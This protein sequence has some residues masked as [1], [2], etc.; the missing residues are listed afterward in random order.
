MQETK[1]RSGKSELERRVCLKCGMYYPT[2]KMLNVHRRW[3]RKATTEELS[4]EEGEGD[5]M[6]CGDAFEF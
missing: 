6:D 2:L 1:H 3:C 4:E 5:E